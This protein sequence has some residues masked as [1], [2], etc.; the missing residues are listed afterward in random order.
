MNIYISYSLKLAVRSKHLLLMVFFIVSSLPIMAQVPQKITEE[1][2]LEDGHLYTVA[3]YDKK[4]KKCLI[5]S[6]NMTKDSGFSFQYSKEDGDV[7]FNLLKRNPLFRVIKKEGKNYLYC[8]D[9]QKYLSSVVSQSFILFDEEGTS[10]QRE[11]VEIPSFSYDGWVIGDSKTLAFA[12]SGVFSG[13]SKNSNNFKSGSNVRYYPAD[14]YSCD[15]IAGYG[16]LQLSQEKDLSAMSGTDKTITF[17]RAFIDDVYNTLV[18]PMDVPHYQNVF[19]FGVKAYAPKESDVRDVISFEAV[20]DDATLEAGVPYILTGKFFSSPYIIPHATINTDG[21]APKVTTVNSQVEIVGT[22]AKLSDLSGSG[23]YG[24]SK[25]GGVVHLSEGKTATLY[26]Y[27]WYIKSSD[28]NAKFYIT[29]VVTTS[30]SP[31][32]VS[33]QEPVDGSLYNLQ[34]VKVGEGAAS[35]AALPHGIYIMNGKK[36]V[37]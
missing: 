6:M 37:K 33:S 34:G 14:L 20:A 30:V 35:A 5:C 36:I 7:T 17:Y 21:S 25:S 26:P 29:G 8:V 2:D 23:I 22:Y 4:S 28:A 13:Y 1:S 15:G 12:S 16:D 10:F 24:C 19:G 31:V 9:D 18:L 27:S 11:K 32:H 3:Y